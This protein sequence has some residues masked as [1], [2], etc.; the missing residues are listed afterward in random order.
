M[1]TN[2]RAV[3]IIKGDAG[4]NG[5]VSFEQSSAGG[6]TTIKGKLNN[7]PAGKHG[8]HI[9]QFGDLSNGCTSAGAHFNPHGKTHGGPED[10]VRHVGDMG[11]VQSTGAEVT[12]FTITDN[13]IS[14]IG[15]HSVI[16][17]S[18]VI[19]EKEDDLGRGG[20][21][22]SLKTGNAGSRLACGVIGLAQ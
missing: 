17:R 22:E 18:V 6:A 8:F 12:E 21:E 10:E 13:L 20:N 11:N 5:V 15:Q 3:V 4:V 19:H 16:G 1:S 14:L 9:H 7:L 2:V